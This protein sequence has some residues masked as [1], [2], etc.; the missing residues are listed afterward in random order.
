MLYRTV[1]KKKGKKKRT[2]S[3]YN[4]MKKNKVGGNRIISLDFQSL[5]APEFKTKFLTFK[6]EYENSI[7]D[8]CFYNGEKKQHIT[9]YVTLDDNLLGIFNTDKYIKYLS[10]GRNI[11]AYAVYRIE[12][13][14]ILNLLLL[15][16][17]N[18]YGKGSGKILLDNIYK[19]FVDEKDFIMKLQPATNGSLFQYYLNWKTPS[20]SDK[21]NYGEIQVEEIYDE[22]YGYLFYI[23]SGD[24]SRIP[25]KS[26]SS[27]GNITTICNFLQINNSDN[28]ILLDKIKDFFTEKMNTIDKNNYY[29]GQIA[30]KIQNL[31]IPF[32]KFYL[33]SETICLDKI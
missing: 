7:N 16:S 27:F 3:K 24:I 21:I 4:T 32:L 25:K 23:K 14:Y 26:F 15:C 28:C 20:F 1:K 2:L 18:K 29:I 9:Q 17:N 5:D 10:D 30:Y 22:S 11:L 8:L 31:N 13:E 19:E 6:T 12:D 33:K